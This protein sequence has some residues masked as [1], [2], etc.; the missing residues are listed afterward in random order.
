M[1]KEHKEETPPFDK[2]PVKNK[3]TSL[4][5]QSLLSLVLIL[6]ILV[7][8]SLLAY[9]AHAVQKMRAAFNHIK[10]EQSE[11]LTEVHRLEKLIQQTK[12]EIKTVQEQ[13]VKA[14]TTTKNFNQEI[15]YT[16]ARFYLDLAKINAYWSYDTETTL[17]LLR[18]ADL[19]LNSSTNPKVVLVRQAI[20]QEMQSIKLATHF[21]SIGMWTEL[22]AIKNIIPTLPFREPFSKQQNKPYEK[23]DKKPNDWHE[24]WQKTRFLLQNL[25]R[26]QKQNDPEEALFSPGYQAIMQESI[27]LDLQVAQ[28]ALLRFETKLY[29][30]SLDG[31]MKNIQKVFD[32]MLPSVKTIIEQLSALKKLPL[33]PKDPL[34]GQSLELM[35]TLQT[36][37][38]T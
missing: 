11:T 32:P 10:Q 36:E 16:K 26:I 1:A 29:Q 13:N 22:N 25:V 35:N 20:H 9:Q 8:A 12:I 31:A 21:D 24:Q 33:S 2:A 23:I 34:I 14:L 37:E 18:E 30:A 6:S 27:I 5:W 17:A 38:G 19:L 15:L 28:G 4:S 7:L 3:I